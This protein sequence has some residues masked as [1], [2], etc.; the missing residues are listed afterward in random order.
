MSTSDK[1]SC[2]GHSSLTVLT[3]HSQGILAIEGGIDITSPATLEAH[4][5]RG[6]SQVVCAVGPVFGR[7]SDGNMGCVFLELTSLVEYWHR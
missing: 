5:W 4:L 7:T 3:S 1:A 6:V 2:L